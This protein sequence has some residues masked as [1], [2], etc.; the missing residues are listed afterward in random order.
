LWEV[1]VIGLRIVFIDLEAQQGHDGMVHY[2]IPGVKGLFLMEKQQA[3]HCASTSISVQFVTVLNYNMIT[4]T[5]ITMPGNEGPMQSIM[6]LLRSA[7]TLS[8]IRNN[9]L[10]LTGLVFSGLIST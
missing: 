8:A 10:N 2:I 7:M 1:Q 5:L 3:S 4:T 9:H 6:K